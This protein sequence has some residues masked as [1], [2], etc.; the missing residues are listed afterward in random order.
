MPL[1]QTLSEQ[2]I[3]R[4]ASKFRWLRTGEEAFPPM[5][6]AIEAARSTVRL[7]MYIYAASP[8]GEQFR[9]ALVRAQQRRVQVHVL[10][11]S[12][13]SFSLPF[14]FWDPLRDAGGVCRWFNPLKLF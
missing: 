14:N 3:Q 9:D 13:G 8:L 5:L 1:P 4:Q 12:L 2:E 11:D 10:V 7:E 6:A